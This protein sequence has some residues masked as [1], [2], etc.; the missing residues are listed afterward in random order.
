M[1][2][3]CSE[4][5]SRAVTVRAAIRDGLRWR[6]LRAAAAADRAQ[7]RADRAARR[8]FTAEGVAL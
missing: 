3:R 7:A 4:C 8:A 1:S 2:N 5:G 6:A